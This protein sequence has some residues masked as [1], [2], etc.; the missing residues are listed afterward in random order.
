MSKAREATKK[1][2]EE[3]EGLWSSHSITSSAG[4]EGRRDHQAERL[5]CVEVDSQLVPG[6]L[7]DRQV[8]GP[9]ALENPVDESCS[10]AGERC[11]VGGVAHQTAR[12]HVVLCPE[13]GRQ[14]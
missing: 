14:P 2:N 13:H 10:P 3:N 6:R 9:L 8:G 7:L 1:S 12:E 4:E 5:G 11:G